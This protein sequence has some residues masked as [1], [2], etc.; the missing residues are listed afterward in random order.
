MM[1]TR[2][3]ADD[4]G[5]SLVPFPEGRVVWVTMVRVCSKDGFASRITTL[6][7]VC[8]ASFGIG[9]IGC[10]GSVA[11]ESGS[12]DPPDESPLVQ[13]DVVGTQR[14]AVSYSEAVVIVP[15]DAFSES[16]SGVLIA[17]R[18][19]LTAAHCVVYV[20][21]RSWTVT[22][23]FAMG[24]EEKK[25]ARDGE[26]MD[27]AFRN[28]TREDY[29][30]RELR[31]VGLLYLDTPFENVK[32]AT[33][34][35]ATY[36]LEKTA[37]PVFVSSVGRSTEGVQ[38]GPALTQPTMLDLPQTSRARIDYVTQRITASG[39]SGGPL[40]LEGT[41]KLVGVHAHSGTGTKTDAWARLDG[42]VYTW[43]TQKVASHGGFSARG[44][45]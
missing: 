28:V 1:R 25:V 26:P 44:E 36:A 15:N 37:P 16:C 29:A 9:A 12:S 34:S 23:P 5:E 8:V 3:S 33:L 32:V 14:S 39:E 19:V 43:M 21:T 17:P 45:P 20:T 2:S 27:A 13:A 11:D 40:F 10:N 42:D 24:G 31:D 38:A 22:A 18:V 7:F 6:S 30:A 41:H 4:G 35:P